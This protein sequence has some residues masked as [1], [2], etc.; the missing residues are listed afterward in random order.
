MK[1][2]ELTM[3]KMPNPPSSPSPDNKASGLAY[4]QTVEQTLAALQTHTNGLSRAE[5]DERLNKYG[6]NALPEKKAKPA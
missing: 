3:T 5:A 1:L 4:Q 2:K 6:P